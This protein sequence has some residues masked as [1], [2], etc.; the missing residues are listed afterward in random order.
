MHRSIVKRLVWSLDDCGLILRLSFS[1]PGSEILVE[2]TLASGFQ[3]PR[4]SLIFSGMQVKMTLN[5]DRILFC[6]MIGSF[7]MST[8][9]IVHLKH[10][11]PFVWSTGH[12]SPLAPFNGPDHPR[13]LSHWGGGL[14]WE[15]GRMAN[16][17]AVVGSRHMATGFDGLKKLGEAS[18]K[19]AMTSHVIM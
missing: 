9:Q 12:V 8:S 2:A 16:R 15:G 7:Q 17:S 14:L 5:S 1:Q 4:S 6:Y 11:Q 19:S 18:N 10:G 13:S 3:G